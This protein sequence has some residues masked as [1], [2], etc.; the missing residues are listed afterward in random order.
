MH[1]HFSENL[2][3]I[4]K[5]NNLSQEQLADE[6]NVSRQAISKW[7]SQTAYPEMDKILTLCDKFDLNIDDLLHKNIAEIKSEEESKKSLNKTIEDFLKF[8]TNTV[9]LFSN[10]TFKSK[11]KCLFEEIIIIFIL[12]IIS[13]LI[14][15]FGSSIILSILSFLPSSIKYFSYN[16]IE[17]ILILF[18]TTSSLI[19]LT[20]VFK[21]RYLDYYDK[22]KKDMNTKNDN[23]SNDISTPKKETINFNENSNKIIIRDPIHSEYHFINSLFKLI[24]V[25]IKFFASL[26]TL[27]ICLILISLFI[28]FILSF[29]FI[30]SGIFFLGLL[31]TILALSSLTIIILLITLNFIF[32]RKNAKQKLIW[33]FII[34]TIIFGCGLGLIIMGTLN[35]EIFNDNTLF[36]TEQTEFTMNDNTYLTIYNTHKIKYVETNIPNIKLEYKI[37]KYFKLVKEETKDNISIWAD[38]TN[39]IKLTKEFIKDLNNKKILS[40]EEPLTDI[41]I[42]AS[43]ENI[44][45]L[46]NNSQN[47]TITY[48]EKRITELETNIDNYETKFYEYEDKI[49]ELNSK[50]E[51]YKET[52]NMYENE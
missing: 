16:I 38:C 21:T 5:E 17:T 37:N 22:L 18:C 12:T 39:P 35:F 48:Y 33:S 14:T 25:I 27:F 47:N 34:S 3:R 9:N 31:T 43:K 44:A 46:K 30:K 45:K 19:I 1:N 28:C 42:Y 40:S 24:I 32:N 41:V 7:E 23:L 10:M 8:I 52:I 13:C 2:K 36:K 26:F 50:L 11:I 15:D 51:E 20:H 4:R 49:S 6:L 29:L